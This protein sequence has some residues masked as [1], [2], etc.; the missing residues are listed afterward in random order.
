M[1]DQPYTNADLRTEA[2]RQHA[3]LTDDPDFTGVGEMMQDSN[4]HSSGAGNDSKT[5]DELLPYDGDEGDAYEEAQ[6]RVCTLVHGAADLSS[7]AV[8]LGADGLQP[9]EQ[10]LDIGD[11]RARVHFAFAPDMSEADRRDFISMIAA[12]VITGS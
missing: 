11:S 4:V 9:S 12:T 1:T 5:W 10:R 7:W 3:A 6:R 8:N 2:A